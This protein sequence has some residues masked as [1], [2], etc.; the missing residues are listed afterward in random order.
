M[1]KA[2]DLQ[3]NYLLTTDGG[4][5]YVDLWV[6]RMLQKVA[7]KYMRVA[8]AAYNDES[9]NRT[10]GMWNH[11]PGKDENPK[12]KIKKIRRKRAIKTRAKKLSGSIDRMV[13]VYA[14]KHKEQRPA[15]AAAAEKRNGG[16]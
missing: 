12:E 6:L 14:A 8:D 3:T 15:D 2:D 4:R 1:A 9:S 16:K 11:R 7:Q 5:L 10:L 13:R